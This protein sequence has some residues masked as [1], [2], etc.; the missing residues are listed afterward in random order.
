M[1][2]G[3]CPVVPLFYSFARALPSKRIIT[4]IDLK[5]SQLFAYSVSPCLREQSHSYGELM[6]VHDTP[7]LLP[8]SP[9]PPL[10]LPTSGS[11]SPLGKLT[12]PAS[13]RLP[14]ILLSCPRALGVL[15]EYICRTL[16]GAWRTSDFREMGAEWLTV[17]VST[18]WGNRINLQCVC[19]YERFARSASSASCSVGGGVQKGC[20]HTAELGDPGRGWRLGVPGSP[21]GSVSEGQRA[22]VGRLR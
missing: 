19:G 17:P 8:A 3:T 5:S 6:G 21:M 4:C 11:S 15:Y 1:S 16:H 18:H 12:L 10:P 22:R 20:L 7:P 13:Y 2:G 14:L 9:C